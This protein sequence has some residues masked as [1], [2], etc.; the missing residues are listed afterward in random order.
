MLLNAAVSWPISSRVVTSIDPSSRPASTA[1][2]PSSSRRTGPGNAGA[3]E[4]REH[5]SKDGRKHRQDHGDDNGRLLVP[6]RHHGI[7]ADLRQHFRADDLDLLVEFVAQ[8]VGPRKLARA[9]AILP[10]SSSGSI[11]LFL[12]PR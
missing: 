2:V 7:A 9:S 5:Q 4:E 10:A 3:D 8:R 12:R 1:R 11:R 6:H